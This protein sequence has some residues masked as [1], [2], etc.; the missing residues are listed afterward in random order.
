[1]SAS[2]AAATIAATQAAV[3]KKGKR[4]GLAVSIDTSTA[5]TNIETIDV[6]EEDGTKLP[7]VSTERAAQTPR[8]VTGGEE[9]SRSGAEVPGDL[10]SQKRAKK[11][12]PKPIKLGLKTTSK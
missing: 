4:R 12:P 8:K 7:D 10:R 5:S 3:S 2:K 6:E 9:C 1:M 11:A